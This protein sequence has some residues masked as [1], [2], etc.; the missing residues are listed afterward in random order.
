MARAPDSNSR[1]RHVDFGKKPKLDRLRTDQVIWG[2]IAANVAVFVAWQRPELLMFMAKHFL[3]S[4]ESVTN[5]RIW[6]LLT[7]EFS[8]RDAMH[9]FFNMFGLY[10]F[11]R[12]IGQVRGPWEVLQV[13]VVGAILASV[14]HVMFTGW[15][16]DGVPALGASG[17]IMALAAYF[18][19]MYPDRTLIVLFFP[20]PAA[21]AVALFI[22]VDVFGLATP[23]S[24]IAH[25][26]HLGGAAYGLAYYQ[27]VVEPQL[28]GRGR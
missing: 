15:F 28:R 1:Y 9:L 8:H 4:V 17:A 24:P 16:G 3:V 11:G 26:A 5:Q 27:L 7:S 2:I 21:A 18:G 25:A 14:A 19:A 10:V 6:T 12:P 20:M 22:L 23:G 13:Y